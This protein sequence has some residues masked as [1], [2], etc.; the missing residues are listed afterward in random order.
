MA[1]KIAIS[2][3]TVA[4]AIA[5]LTYASF[6]NKSTG[7]SPTAT[8]SLAPSPTPTSDV[9]PSVLSAQQENP[10]QKRLDEQQLNP[11]KPTEAPPPKYPPGHDPF[12]AFVDAQK[13]KTENAQTSPFEK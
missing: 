4:V 11:G 6:E 7:T 5:I 3:A 1:S 13:Q 12:K 10:F 9:S 8:S 2:I